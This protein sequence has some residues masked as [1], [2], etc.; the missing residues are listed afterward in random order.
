MNFHA[1]LSPG[2][3]TFATWRWHICPNEGTFQHWVTEQKP[4]KAE[5]ANGRPGAIGYL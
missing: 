5:F 4:V 1:L 3:G 2:H